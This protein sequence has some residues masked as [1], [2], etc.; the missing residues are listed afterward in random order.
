MLNWDQEYYT[1]SETFSKFVQ[2]SFI[3]LMESGFIHRQDRFI[4]WSSKLQTAI[5]DIEVEHEGILHERLVDVPGCN[6]VPFGV[7][8]KL[9]FGNNIFVCT[10]RPETSFGDVALCVHPSDNRYKRFIG[11]E[12]KHPITKQMIPMVCD[13]SVDMTVGSGVVK[14][15]PSVSQNDYEIAKRNGLPVDVSFLTD[16]GLVNYPQLPKYHVS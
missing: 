8:Y 3:Q 6:Q 4:N 10:T 14:I 13:E 15:T 12:F 16:D 7:M 1:K 9:Y 5:A 11:E 2:D